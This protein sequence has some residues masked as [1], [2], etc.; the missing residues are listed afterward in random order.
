[1]KVGIKKV[2]VHRLPNGENCMILWSL[3]LSQYM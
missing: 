3:I 2:G 1:M